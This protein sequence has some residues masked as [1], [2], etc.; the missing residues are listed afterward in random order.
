[1]STNHSVGTIAKLLS[2]TVRR[3]QQLA[4][5]G[6][7]P[8]PEDGKYHLLSC[9]T[10]YIKYLQSRNYNKEH[11]D[12]RELRSKLLRAQLIKAQMDIKKET[13]E[14]WFRSEA[15]AAWS[16]M[17]LAFRSR[18]LSVPYRAACRVVGLKDQHEVQEIIRELIYEALDELSDYD[19][20]IESVKEES[21]EKDME[22]NS[23]VNKEVVDL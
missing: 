21:V 19:L 23:K 17:I 5:D 7:I 4:R 16:N 10:G 11:S 1:M 18:M 3:V 20:K 2:I 12:E 9:F 8:K 6:I 15:E 14:L 13:K 22:P